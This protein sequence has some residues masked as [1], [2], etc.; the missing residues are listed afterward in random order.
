M[1]HHCLYSNPTF[2]LIFISAARQLA[3]TIPA[4][5]QLINSPTSQP[6]SSRGTPG[7]RI[8]VSPR[9]L[10]DPEESPSPSKLSTDARA[11]RRVT[12]P[13]Y[14][15]RSLDS[16]QLLELASAASKSPAAAGGQRL[17]SASYPAPQHGNS[18]RWDRTA[19]AAAVASVP[20]AANY[21]QAMYQ[22]RS[23]GA[24]QW[25]TAQE[26]EQSGSSWDASTEAT[27]SGK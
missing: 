11:R 23:A 20:A 1:L 10:D 2:L 26:V 6:T 8:T 15:H 21:Q 3:V 14:G 22:D 17:L 9:A 12:A 5:E 27:D 13:E 19:G 24:G 18:P 4:V 16:L 7:Y 25:A